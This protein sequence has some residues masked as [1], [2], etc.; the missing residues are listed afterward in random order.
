M[1]NND[2]SIVVIDC[3]HY[4]ITSGRDHVPV[5]NRILGL[6]GQD[7]MLDIECHILRLI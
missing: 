1:Q 5:D 3:A 6:R 7:S 2:L 4:H